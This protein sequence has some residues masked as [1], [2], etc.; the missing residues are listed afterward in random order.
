MDYVRRIAESQGGSVT[1]SQLEAFTFDGVII[2]LLDQSRGI[3]NPQQ[4]PATLT[5]G[6]FLNSP[7][8]DEL[9]PEGLHR[10]DMRAGPAD[11]GDNRKL[12]LASDHGVPLIWLYQTKDRNF[13]PIAPVYLTG[14][15][16]GGRSYVLALGEDLMLLSNAGLG[17]TESVLEKRF[18][19]TMSKRRLHQPLFRANVMAAY[20]RKCAICSLAHADLLDAA[21]IVEDREEGGDPVVPNGLSL[22]KIHHAAYDRQI[23]GISPD[24]IVKVDSDVLSEVDGPMLKHGI[25]E[26]HNSPLRELPVRTLDWPD[27]DRLALRFERFLQGA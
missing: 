24:R 14:L 27:S 23:L 21:H 20:Q 4:L 17:S 15:D 9:G 10:Y 8:R 26:L 11:S 19:R 12:R 2:K 18:A 1:R 25:Q 5:I 3:R 22:C 13:V 16:S 6:T 7:Y